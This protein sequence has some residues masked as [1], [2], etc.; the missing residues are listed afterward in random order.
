MQE[1]M[2]KFTF[3][4]QH[5][6]RHRLPY[7]PLIFTHVVESLVFVPIMVRERGRE[8]GREGGSVLYTAV[9]ARRVCRPKKTNKGSPPTSVTGGVEWSG[10]GR[11]LCE[12][13]LPFACPRRCR[14]RCRFV[15]SLGLFAKLKFRARGHTKVY[16]FFPSLPVLP[17][18]LCCVV[19]LS[20][21]YILNTS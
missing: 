4:L 5:H 14:C 21:G 20:E 1:R 8:G 17:S 9:M 16:S 10:G 13:D 2:L 11:T 12:V 15:L 18:R 7:A 3:L 6:V 19:V